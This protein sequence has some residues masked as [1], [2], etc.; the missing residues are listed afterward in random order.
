LRLAPY[1]VAA[2]GGAG[3]AVALGHIPQAVIGDFDSIPRTAIRA[4]P[5]ERL[6]RFEDQD[7]TDFDKCL[8]SIDAPLCLAVGFLGGR[9]DHELAVMSTLLRQPLPPCILVGAEDVILAAPR[10]LALDLPVGSRLSLF[11]MAPVSGRSAGLRWPIAGIGFA[12]DT[13]IGTSNEVTGPVRLEFD[14]PG[15]LVI[16]PRAALAE[17]VRAVSRGPDDARA[18]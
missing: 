11:P 8:S 3:H 14:G 5:R 1:L 9:I 16:T 12:P 17:V 4:I 7:S 6:H 13:R 15:M 2:D 18:R 10:A